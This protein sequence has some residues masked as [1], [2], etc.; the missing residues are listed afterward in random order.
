MNYIR[1]LLVRQILWMTHHEAECILAPGDA[2][3]GD[4]R[5]EGMTARLFN[6]EPFEEPW[7]EDDYR[8]DLTAPEWCAVSGTLVWEEEACRLQPAGGGH[9]MAVHPVCGTR[10]RGGGGTAVLLYDRKN[11]VTG[12]QILVTEAEYRLADPFPSV[13]DKAYMLLEYL[14]LEPEN[15]EMVCR[16][17]TDASYAEEA[18][19]LMGELA[20][21]AC[22]SDGEGPVWEPAEKQ[23]LPELLGV[24]EECMEKDLRLLCVLLAVYRLVCLFEEMEDSI[25]L[26]ELMGA[27]A[28]CHHPAFEDCVER[29]LPRW[30]ADRFAKMLLSAREDDLDAC[31]FAC[32]RYWLFALLKARIDLSSQTLQEICR[33]HFCQPMTGR[34]LRSVRS[35]LFS[36][37][38][39]VIR[40][41]I[42]G[43]Y[44]ETHVIPSD[45]LPDAMA[46]LRIHDL[47]YK[48]AAI[49]EEAQRLLLEGTGEN[50]TLLGIAMMSVYLQF[51]SELI[52]SHRE[53]VVL[54]RETEVTAMVLQLLKNPWSLCYPYAC[55]LACQL[56]LS[57][58]VPGDAFADPQVVHMACAAWNE[59]ICPSRV[60]KL[61]STLPLGMK[62]IPSD[63]LTRM[64]RFLGK[65]L[66]AAVLEKNRRGG[67]IRLF[68][69]CAVLGCWEK[70]H[71]RL[72]YQFLLRKIDGDPEYTSAENREY[73]RRLAWDMLQLVTGPAGEDP[74][75]KAEALPNSTEDSRKMLSL[76]RRTLGRRNGDLDPILPLFC[77]DP[78]EER[79][80]IVD[81]FYALCTLGLSEEAEALYLK[82]KELLD[83]PW[84]YLPDPT[85]FAVERPY[86]A[87]S[88]FWNRQTRREKGLELAA[89]M[90]HPVEQWPL[91]QPCEQ[92]VYRR[93]R[94]VPK[95]GMDRSG[96]LEFFR[97]QH[98]PG[99]KQKLNYWMTH[100]DDASATRAALTEPGNH[101]TVLLFGYCGS[102]E[103]VLAAVEAEPSHVCYASKAL[104]KDDQ[105]AMAVLM[106]SCRYLHLLF[107]PVTRNR[108]LIR[109]LILQ[110]GEACSL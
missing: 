16:F 43:M 93:R 47:E 100:Y 37:N 73:M 51:R 11:P 21:K 46:V 85:G 15:R 17:L 62:L 67:L 41:C 98:G 25:A 94:Y 86:H 2:D 91:A 72:R 61:V 69:C 59:R 99:R 89:G 18:V 63:G 87:A 70:E 10:L 12:D 104:L 68:R 23:G 30:E 107:A 101:S 3:P 81:W 14:R 65:R 44:S 9:P 7:E 75:Q 55:E 54:S 8:L 96:V 56:Y 64:R 57:C 79:G 90:G 78:P 102:K 20:L 27:K 49:E 28:C 33:R 60:E 13:Y 36:S 80:L 38:G 109:R 29:T 92:D 31:E 110:Q 66:D 34:L 82:H 53:P 24:F 42:E 4:L 40:E 103:M 45:G 106:Q 48:A 105:V 108:E 88:C 35:S 22:Q 74:G 84:I 39:T 6:A 97:K 1:N 71:L 83:L 52:R 26:E 77:S 95:P 58:G 32:V 76:F 50:E 19:S 5:M